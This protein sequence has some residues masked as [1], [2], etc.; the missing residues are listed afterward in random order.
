MRLW[1]K[2]QILETLFS[3]KCQQRAEAQKLPEILQNPLASAIIFHL[4]QFRQI[5]AQIL[6][7]K[8]DF[9]PVSANIWKIAVFCKIIKTLAH[10][11]IIWVWRGAKVYQSCRAWKMLS[12]EPTLAIRFVDTAE[13]EPSK[14]WK[15]DRPF[16]K[17]GL[18][19]TVRRSLAIRQA[20]RQAG[21]QAER[22]ERAGEREG[23][24]ASSTDR[25]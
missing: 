17:F 20:G 1:P 6:A 23:E 13:N 16:P 8:Y 4:P 2:V 24:R 19:A 14:V 9:A 12:N 7:K 11:W 25:P 22:Q 18:S 10:F 15:V 21:R 3:R 5:S